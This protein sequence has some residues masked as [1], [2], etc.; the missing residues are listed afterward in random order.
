MSS[1]TLLI[2]KGRRNSEYMYCD[3][4]TTSRWDATADLAATMD[5]DNR[6]DEWKSWYDHVCGYVAR[7]KHT[8]AQAKS[9]M[10]DYSSMIDNAVILSTDNTSDCSTALYYEDPVDSR[11]D[12]FEIT[13]QSYSGDRVLNDIN[14]TYDINAKDPFHTVPGFADETRCHVGESRLTDDGENQ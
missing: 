8:F 13:E 10:Q 11:Y 2:A 9:I 5:A 14:G 12:R 1:W 7:Q 6:I 3:Y 4:D